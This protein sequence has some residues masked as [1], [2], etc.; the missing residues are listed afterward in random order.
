MGKSERLYLKEWI[1]KRGITRAELGRRVNAQS[2]TI[3]SWSAGTPPPR[4]DD[5]IALAAALDVKVAD[6][7]TKP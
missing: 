1:A 7:F 5:L 6:L 3:K 2:I 4:A